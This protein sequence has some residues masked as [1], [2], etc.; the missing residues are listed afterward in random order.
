MKSICN[1]E[2]KIQSN[3]ISFNFF[4]LF[5][6]LKSPL[7]NL[8]SFLVMI[9]S[10]RSGTSLKLKKEKQLVKGTLVFTF[11]SKEENSGSSNRIGNIKFTFN[12]H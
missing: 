8:K 5:I 2:I 9:S 7:N 4:F 10:F 11:L 12:H 3:Y 1:I 6:S